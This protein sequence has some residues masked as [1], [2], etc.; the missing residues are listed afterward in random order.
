MSNDMTSVPNPKLG[1]NTTSC[2]FLCCYD[3][4]ENQLSG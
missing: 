3:L 4:H 1:K 2:A